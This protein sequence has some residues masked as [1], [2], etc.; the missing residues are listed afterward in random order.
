MSLIE[1]SPDSH[2]FQWLSQPNR[3]VQLSA[4]QYIVEKRRSLG[5]LIF[6]E[7][8]LLLE[9]YKYTPYEQIKVVI[10]GQD[11][12]HGFGQ[13]DGLAFSVPKNMPIPPSLKN[14]FKEIQR[15]IP[16]SVHEHGDLHAWA[17]Q[18]VFLLNTTLSVAQS[19]PL[20]HQSLNWEALT[21]PTLQHIAEKTDPV[22]FL[23]WGKQAQNAMKNIDTGKHIVLSTVHPS[24]LSAY[25]GFFGCGHFSLVNQFLQQHQRTPINWDIR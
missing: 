3:S 13:A 8:S 5:E 17:T 23:L 15:D 25:R 11:P 19:K 21:I 14:I 1:L 20:S 9:A 16:G 10:L 4:I 22:A 6:P 7:D 18:G 12:Y 2:W 24:P